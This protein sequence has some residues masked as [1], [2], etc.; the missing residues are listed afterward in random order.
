MPDRAGEESAAAKM[1]LGRALFSREVM[2][3]TKQ[4]CFIVTKVE[5][6]QDPMSDVR[7]AVGHLTGSP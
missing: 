7:A 3:L 5:M 4:I 2:S 6:S 1:T